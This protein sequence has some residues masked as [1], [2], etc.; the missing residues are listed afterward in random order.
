MEDG[1]YFA[2]GTVCKE[3]IEKVLVDIVCNL[4]I[5]QV[6]K[7]VALREVVDRDDV[8]NTACV[9]AFDDVAANKSCSSGDDN[10]HANNSS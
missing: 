1:F 3:F 4:Q 5:G 2:V 9:Q 8:V 10:L 7:L 6:D